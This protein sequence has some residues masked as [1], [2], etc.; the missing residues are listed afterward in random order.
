MFSNMVYQDKYDLLE[1]DFLP[2]LWKVVD[3]HSRS[4]IL[5]SHVLKLRFGLNKENYDHTLEEV[6]KI[7][8]VT[9]E[10]IRQIEVKALEKARIWCRKNGYRATL[11]E[12]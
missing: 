6:G 2:A 10:R 3:E 5:P 12:F 11:F 8:G 4:S 7:L 1:N 9:R